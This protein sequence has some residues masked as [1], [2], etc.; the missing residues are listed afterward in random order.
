MVLI[1]KIGFFPSFY[2]WENRP[3][4]IQKR[5]K[6]PFRLKTRSKKKNIEKLAFFKR[7]QYMVLVKKRSFFTFIFFAN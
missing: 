5:K 3:G 7:G 2:F 6:R 4:D 1:R